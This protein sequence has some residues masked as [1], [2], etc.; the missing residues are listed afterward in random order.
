MQLLMAAL[1][2]AVIVAKD[3]EAVIAAA[4]ARM[5]VEQSQIIASDAPAAH[6]VDFTATPV[7]AARAA[8]ADLQS[9]P[10]VQQPVTRYVWLRNG[11]PDELALMSF[12]VNSTLSRVNIGMLPGDHG[13]MTI[14]HGGRLVR[15]DLS[16]I[17][18]EP[19]ELA[20]LIT[21]WERLAD[22]ETDFTVTVR[23]DRIVDVNPPVLHQGKLFKRQHRTF[24]I[25]GPAAHVA[26]EIAAMGM[27]MNPVPPEIG[28]PVAVPIIESREFIETAL[29]TLEGG[30]YYEFRGIDAKWT[31]KEY[32]ASR[33]AS[34]EQVAQL[35][36]L[37][38][39]VKLTSKI[40]GK[41]RMVSLFR[42][43]GVR[44]STG[45]GLVSLTYDPFD[46]DRSPDA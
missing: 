9:L 11:T 34:E 32:L 27:L 30:L 16:L 23:E 1:F 4:P 33:G 14:L 44:A 18:T 2:T 36:S 45:G 17:A 22:V 19:A 37:E 25:Q 7:W 13:A 5:P 38:K 28:L 8:L 10:P 42:G 3:A 43:A 20:N 21:T 24:T 29:T 35:E 6:A 46:E 15:L 39:A 40:T 31:L 26:D 41:E 12:A